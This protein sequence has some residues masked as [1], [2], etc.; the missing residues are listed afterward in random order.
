M[1]QQ[2]LMIREMEQSV[3]RRD[4]IAYQGDAKILKSTKSRITRGNFQKKLNEIERKIKN[5]QKVTSVLMTSQI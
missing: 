3:T 2:E 4:F 5:V 1:K